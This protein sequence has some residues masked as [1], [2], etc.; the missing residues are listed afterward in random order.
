MIRVLKK[1]DTRMISPKLK[2]LTNK[3]GGFVEESASDPTL[4]ESKRARGISSLALGTEFI[5]GLGC[6]SRY[7]F[8]CLQNDDLTVSRVHTYPVHLPDPFIRDARHFRS[9]H[10]MTTNTFYARLAC[11]PCGGFGAVGAAD[12]SIFLF[13]LASKRRDSQTAIRLS[14]HVKEIGGI[15]WGRH[16]V[17]RIHIDLSLLITFLQ[18]ASCSDDRTIRVWRHN[19]DVYQSCVVDP[20]KNAWH[21]LW[22]A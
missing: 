3:Y 2:M 4:F 5:F 14:G 17:S 16:C 12:G 22:S 7:V 1:W 8:L 13:D 6:D 20:G 18:I 10:A 15:D 21:W 11:S 19:E 9:D